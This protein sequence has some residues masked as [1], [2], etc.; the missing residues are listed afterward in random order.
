MC[1]RNCDVQQREIASPRAEEREYCGKAAEADIQP[2]A[3]PVL[4]LAA[5][6]PAAPGPRGGGGSQEEEASLERVQQE[7]LG[8]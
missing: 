5:A 8:Q 4:P 7:T 1:L 2:A 3:S 6:L